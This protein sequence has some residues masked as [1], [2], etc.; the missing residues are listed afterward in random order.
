[1]VF[2]EVIEGFDIVAKIEANPCDKRDKPLA[3]VTIADS[4]VL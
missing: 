4:G 2:G 1:M 3:A